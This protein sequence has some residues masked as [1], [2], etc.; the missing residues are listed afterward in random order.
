[1]SAKARE[2]KIELQEQANK[3]ERESSVFS[4]LSL[5]SAELI[6]AIFVNYMP[7]VFILLS[8]M[9]NVCTCI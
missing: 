6:Y 7:N 2:F 1:M 8:H 4:S 5:V 9:I 3:R